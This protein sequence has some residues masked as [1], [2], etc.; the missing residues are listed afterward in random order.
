MNFDILNQIVQYASNFQ[1]LPLYAKMSGL[2]LIIVSIAKSSMIQPYWDKLG[3]AKPLVPPVL[4]IIVALI[5]IHPITM[6]AV[7]ESLMG[8]SLAIAAHELLDALKVVP[9]IGPKYTAFINLMES[10]LRSPKAAPAE[11]KPKA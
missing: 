11:E 5:G 2:V 8:G 6:S 10:L 7:I 9:T 1:S 3:A 4:A